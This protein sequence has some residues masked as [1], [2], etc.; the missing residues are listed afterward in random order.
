M[1][2]LVWLLAVSVA[3][4]QELPTGQ[5][6]DRVTCAA[7]ASQSYALFVPREYTPTQPWP[8]HLEMR[9][10]DRALTSPHRLAIFEGGHV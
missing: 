5:L 3:S 1:I 10:L 4:A 6:I 7:D 8:N 2:R 9:L